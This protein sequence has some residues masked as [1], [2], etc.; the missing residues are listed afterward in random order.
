MR[1]FGITL[2]KAQTAA[3][4]LGIALLAWLVVSSNIRAVLMDLA[5][6]GPGLFVILALEFA[7]DGFNTLGWWFTIPTAA[8]NGIYRRLFWV[9]S[10]G[11]ALSE[12]IPAASLG[13]EPAKVAL[14]SKRIPA[15]AATAS[16]LATKVSFSFAKVIFI[17]AGMAA[18][19]PRLR[20]SHDVSLP[21]LGGFILMLI[22]I[23]IFFVI[24]LRGIG[25]RKIRFLR[26]IGISDRW[27]LLIEESSQGVDHH[28]RDFYRARTGDL[29]RSIGAHFCGFA[30]GILQILLMVRWL[31]LGYDP[32]AA[33]G[34]ESFSTLIRFVAF[35]VPGSLG[36]Q[37]G[38][39]VLI[40]KA[41]GLP[42]SA[43]MAVGIS[44]RL[45]SLVE[46]GVGLVAFLVLQPRIGGAQKVPA[47]SA[48]GFGEE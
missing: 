32:V 4:V 41:L 28:L 16:L 23:T 42:R 43:A 9:R 14:L 12:S 19:W 25:A 1:V 45:I 38:G 2:P 36:V 6:L 20:L 29:F 17:I 8:R 48:L 27:T 47:T 30:C 40:F 13:G 3:F 7:T 31:G 39:K 26:W 22:G 33:V 5:R 11:N 34:I 46:I 21:L 35:A 10:A 37:E 24:Q 18:A 44:F 15:S